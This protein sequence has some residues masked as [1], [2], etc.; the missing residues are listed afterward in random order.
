MQVQV[1]SVAADDLPGIDA[2]LRI[3]AT[4]VPDDASSPEDIAWE[5]ATY[6]GQGQR[7]LALADGEPVGAAT[8]GRIHIY[9]E[10]HPADYLGAWVLPA[11]RGRGAGTALLRACSD[12]ARSRRKTAFQTWV[13]ESEIEGVDFLVHRGFEVIGRDKSV[14]LSL[15][16]LAAPEVAPPPGFAITTLAERP[17]LVA[18]IHRVAVEAY[19]SIP[20]TTPLAVGT[21]EEF[22]AQEIDRPG[23]P[24]EAVCIAIDQR[25]GEVAGYAVLEL[26]RGDPRVAFHDMTAVRPAFRGRGVATA[27]KRATIAWAIGAGLGELRTGNDE[28]NAAM[29]S[30]N[31]ALGYEPRP[32]YL[33]MR[34][35]LTRERD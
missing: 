8:V 16:G 28:E 23:T 22:T 20:S 12:F 29:R 13:S 10:D 3:R 19:P 17:D 2:Y 30:V 9:A 21:L 31:A 1:R 34:G 14:A 26:A 25:S 7:L 33:T 4:V 35:P 24:K 27:L 32:D 15:A 11:R 6:P 5:D 18:G